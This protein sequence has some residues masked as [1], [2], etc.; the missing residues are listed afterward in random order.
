[1]GQRSQQYIRF[2]N[3][4]KLLE[5]ILK[6]DDMSIWR[7]KLHELAIIKVGFDKWYEA[8]GK[9][10]TCIMAVHN[11][12]LYGRS[13][14]LTAL[15]LLEWNKFSKDN[16]N[17]FNKKGY[18]DNYNDF[19]FKTPQD[20][21]NFAK[22]FLNTIMNDPLSQYARGGMER[23]YIMNMDDKGIAKTPSYG[24]CND[25]II[26]IDFISGKYAFM[27]IG[28][29]STV[30]QLPKHK[31]V[32]AHEYIKAYYPESQTKQFIEN[33]EYKKLQ[34]DKWQKL[35]DDNK[36]INNKFVRRFKAFKMLTIEEIREMFPKEEEFK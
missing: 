33:C 35:L 8:F 32:S 6:L 18:R 1:M 13:L 26:V 34:K 12:W 29:D 28:G 25:G 2:D 21:L 11:Q 20:F 4:G 27:N 23:F 5:P 24:D 3:I 7:D 22:L 14:A 17:P 30:E 16:T 10:D 15:K 36:K 31:P 19:N 9:E